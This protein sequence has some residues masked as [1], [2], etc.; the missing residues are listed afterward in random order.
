MM[1]DADIACE[2]VWVYDMVVG[3]G[4]NFSAMTA[5]GIVYSTQISFH[6]LVFCSRNYQT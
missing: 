1:T 3:Q 6:G 5:G 4:P 2:T